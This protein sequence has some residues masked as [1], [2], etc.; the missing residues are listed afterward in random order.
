MDGWM[1]P[2]SST[3]E[4]RRDDARDDR[5]A[6]DTYIYIYIPSRAR[7]SRIAARTSPDD[8]HTAGSRE[9]RGRADRPSSDWMEPRAGSSRARRTLADA[10]ADIE[11][12][13]MADM[14]VVRRVCVRECGTRARI[15]RPS[16]RPTEGIILH[17]SSTWTPGVRKKKEFCV[18]E[19]LET[20]C[21]NGL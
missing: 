13:K 1:I 7:A 6:M 20:R 17:P 16:D 12:V 10:L 21:T 11:V 15:A 3:R 4:E 5:R 9:V 14:V 2:S 8:R 19:V 18:V